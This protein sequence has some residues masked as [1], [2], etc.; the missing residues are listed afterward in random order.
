MRLETTIVILAGT[1]TLLAPTAEAGL[2]S[3]VKGFNGTSMNGVKMQGHML[4]GTGLAGTDVPATR[5]AMPADDAF[6]ANALSLTDVILP[7]P[8]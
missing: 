2:L 1:L 8:E 4:Q 3:F 7:T 5:G 6:D